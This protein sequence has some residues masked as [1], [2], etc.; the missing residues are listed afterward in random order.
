MKFMFAGWIKYQMPEAGC[1]LNN[2]RVWRK[3]FDLSF[4]GELGCGIYF[5]V[6]YDNK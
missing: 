1:G 6:F 5:G 4:I 3:G 2:I